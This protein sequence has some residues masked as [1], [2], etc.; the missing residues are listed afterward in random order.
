MCTVAICINLF[1]MKAQLN[2][3]SCV[4]ASSLGECMVC[5]AA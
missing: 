4:T 3:N 2:K 5:L 1:F